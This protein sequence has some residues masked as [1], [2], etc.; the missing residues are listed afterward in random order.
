MH[1]TRTITTTL[2]ATIACYCLA[3]S[4]LTWALP[5]GQVSIPPLT[6]G[7][8]TGALAYLAF[9]TPSRLDPTT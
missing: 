8:L 4:F 3:I 6:V 5:P 9:K 7:I 2:L 1:T